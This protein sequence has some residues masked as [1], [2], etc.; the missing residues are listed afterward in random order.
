MGLVKIKQLIQREILQLKIRPITLTILFYQFVLL[1]LSRNF[2][3]SPSVVERIVIRPSVYHYMDMISHAL[4]LTARLKIVLQDHVLQPIV[5]RHKLLWATVLFLTARHSAIHQH[6][7]DKIVLKT[8]VFSFVELLKTAFNLI[9]Q[10]L[11][12]HSL[13]ILMTVWL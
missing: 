6:V 3:M 1:N 8:N 12:A 9:V 13:V 10:F 4:S 11:I 7:L 2:V 5:L